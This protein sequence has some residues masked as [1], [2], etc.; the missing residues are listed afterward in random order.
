MYFWLLSSVH[1][2]HD[3]RV[4]LLK[5]FCGTVAFYSFWS[6]IDER[7]RGASQQLSDESVR[8]IL[9]PATLVTGY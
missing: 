8:F 7:D 3:T 9:R 6:P 4:E 1:D 2:T 5:C